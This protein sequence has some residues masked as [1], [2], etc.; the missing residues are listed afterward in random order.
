[1]HSWEQIIETAEPRGHLVQLY[2]NNQALIRNVSRYLWEGLKR[3]DGLLVI[4]TEKHREA[5]FRE[6]QEL[7]TDADAAVRDGRLVLLD[8]EETLAGFMVEGQPDWT[9]FER[10]VLAAMREVHARTG[11]TGLRAY[12]EMVGVLWTAGKFSAAIRLEQFWNQLLASNGFNLYCAYPIDVFHEDFQI[13]AV[14][15][16]LCDHTHLLPTAANGQL[17]NAVNRAMDEILGAAEVEAIRLRVKDKHRSSWA[18]M[19]RAETIILCLRNAFPEKARAIL[20]RARQY[21]EA[22]PVKQ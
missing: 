8:A 16:L 21:Y 12:G 9:R 22:S 10:I 11:R 2:G 15:A 19:P 4:A 1:M 13:S 3:G 5:F 6:L 20:A 7:D 18:M 17:E 14:D